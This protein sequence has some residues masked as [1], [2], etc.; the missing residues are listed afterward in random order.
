MQRLESVAFRGHGHAE[1]QRDR[2][3]HTLDAVQRFERHECRGC[4]GT[5]ELERN[6]F[7]RQ[8][9]LADACGTDQGHESLAR[10]RLADRVEFPATTDQRRT[11]LRDG[12]CG[13]RALRN[14]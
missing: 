5:L 7:L 3:R 13:R 1:R 9:R 12:R 11:L 8:A 10:E 4:V 2:R 14:A 6:Y